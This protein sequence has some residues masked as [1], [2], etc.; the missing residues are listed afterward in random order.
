MDSNRKIKEQYWKFS[1]VEGNQHIASEFAIKKL[2]TVIDELNCH[3]V[4]EVGLGVGSIAGTMLN[5]KRGDR[6]FRYYGVESNKFCL[7][8]LPLNL[9]YDYEN[10]KIYDNIAS[11]PNENLFDLVIV[12]GK[13][14]SLERIK[15]LISKNGILAI[16][17]GRD[18]QQKELQ[19]LFPG[20]IFVHLIS[21][22]K[23]KTYSPFPFNSWQGGLKIIFVKPTFKQKLWW[24]REKIFTKLKYMN[25]KRWNKEK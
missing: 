11:I 23:N 20:Q 3:S 5:L 21:S 15:I 24:M 14:P 12:D 1:H 6:N 13:D 16:E 25:R 19:K 18:E 7:D 8:A 10:L 22:K 9:Q 17:G 2:W 4:L